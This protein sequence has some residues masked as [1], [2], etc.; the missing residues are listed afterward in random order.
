MERTV[1]D[2][3]SQVF[4]IGGSPCSGKSTLAAE[5]GRQYGLAV[6][7]CDDAVER[8]VRLAGPDRAPVMYRLSHASCD[9]LWMRPLHQQVSEEIT[10]YDEEW[11]FILDDLLALPGDRPVIAEGAALMPHLLES[12]GVPHRRSIWLVPSPA[13]QREHYARRAWR[14]DVL[15]QCTHPK[16]AWANWME[17]D[18]DFARHVA[19]EAAALGRT[20]IVVDKSQAV[21]AVVD[22]VRTHF[23]LG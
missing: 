5:L 19:D 9:E 16:Q 23:G 18:I 20:C 8:H 14:H 3:L 6:Y 17:R 12:I 4:W 11:S 13:F 21:E 10:W 1:D 7:T 2:R 15:A 22:S